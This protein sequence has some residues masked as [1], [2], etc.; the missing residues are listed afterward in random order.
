MRPQWLVWIGFTYIV[1]QF[2]CIILQG[3][4]LGG[5]EQNFMNAMTGFSAHQFTDSAIGNIGVF[6]ANVVGGTVGFFTY[7]I[8]RLLWWD[9]SF[10]EG[11]GAFVKWFLLY[12]INLG[13]ALG[14]ISIF[15]R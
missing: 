12:P 4:W 8:P 13:T 14:I 11:G 1:G 3:T 2:M 7:G 10:L 5:P 9:Y 6:I 15:K